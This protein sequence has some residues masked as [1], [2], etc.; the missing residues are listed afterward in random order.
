MAA[1]IADD[2]A[3][4]GGAIRPGFSA[5]LDGLRTTARDARQFLAEIETRERE[6]TGIKS[7]KVGYN[8]VFGY[9]IE[10]S[11]ANAGAVPEDYQR[12]QT[13]VGGERYTT[14]ELSEH[15]YRVLHAQ[16]LEAELEA[17][18]LRQ[19]C[20]QV[21][22]EAPR[23]LETAR[24]IAEVDVLA[25]LAE[26]AS[27]GGWVRPVVDEGEAILVREGRHPVVEAALDEGT[28]VPNDVYLSRDDAQ[29]VLL[30]GPNMAGKSTYLRQVALIVL[31]A[32]MGS[33]VPAREA[34]IGARR[35]RL[36]AGGGAR[37]HRLRALDVHGGDA[38]DGGDAGR[39]DAS[40][41]SSSS[42]RSGGGRAPTTGWRSRGRWSS[43][44]TTARTPAARTLFA[45]HY[46]ELTELSA[47]LPRVRNLHV[48]VAEEDGDVVFLH[49]V[50]PG[51]A[52][53][54]YG[55]HVAQL[56]GLPK[57]VVLRAREILEELE[58]ARSAMPVRAAETRRSSRC[59]H[60]RTT[61]CAGRSG[62]STSTG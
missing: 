14:P 28:F 49:R 15:E 18:L 60:R 3:A 1:A 40:A 9:Y 27:R 7:L 36:L 24:A 23:I 55:V 56:A 42:T 44:C 38:G 17:T 37:R 6:R 10:I 34:R 45:T 47:S 43:S 11:K 21:A 31:L 61:G 52:D 8:R 4:Q 62:R 20:A 50:L 22:A 30:T 12:K 53:R 57:P 2:P 54:S 51:G 16:E 5:E 48:A 19:V 29:V 35:P 41:R 32:Q 39:G 13:L 26:A 33:F 25:S 58:S 46:H 59:S